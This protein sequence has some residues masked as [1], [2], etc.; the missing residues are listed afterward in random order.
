MLPRFQEELSNVSEEFD[1]HV[2]WGR[3]GKWNLSRGRGVSAQ[4]AVPCAVSR[5]N[6]QKAQEER[7]RIAGE[8]FAITN[9]L[10]V[11]TLMIKLQCDINL[12]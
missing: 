1:I 5:V 12:H 4:F 9:T 6:R 3:G 2:F 8:Q 11:P 7:K 10:G